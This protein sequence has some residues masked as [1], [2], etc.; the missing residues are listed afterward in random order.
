MPQPLLATKLFIPSPARS[1]VVRARLLDRLD[2]SLDPAARL[3]LVSAPP[4]FGKTTLLG[5]WAGSFREAKSQEPCRIAWLSL[6]EGDNDPVLFWAYLIAAL[7]TQAEGIGAQALTWLHAPQSPDLKAAVAVLVNDLAQIPGCF[8]LILDDYHVIRLSSIHDSLSFLIERM[9]PQF[10]VVVMTRADPPLP[11]ALLRGRGQLL[12]IRLPELR[13]SD[14]EAY[15]YLSQSAANALSQSDAARL[16]AKAEGWAA[17][18]QMAG[19]SLRG[20]ANVE[21]F[22]TSFSGNSRYILDYLIEEVLNRQTPAVQDFLLATSILDRLSGPLCDSLLAAPETEV[23]E[24][25]A[26]L[27]SGEMLRQLEDSNL[28]IS[29]LDDQRYWYRY[30]RLFADLLTKRL[31]QI[32]PARVGVLHSRASRW[33]EENGFADRAV[34]HAFKAQDYSRAARLVEAL[35]DDLWKQGE[36]TRLLKWL[37]ELTDEQIRAQLPLA[38]F[39]AGLLVL[40]GNLREAELCLDQADEDLPVA[41]LDGALLDRLIGRA[42][43]VRALIAESRADGAGILHYAHL[44]LE[45]LSPSLDAVWRIMALVALGHQELTQGH[46][47]ACKQHLFLA[48]EIGRSAGCF[49]LLLDTMTKLVLALWLAGRL[50]E[51]ADVC[52]EGLQLIDQNGLDRIPATS[53]LYLAWGFILFESRRSEEAKHFIL[54][55]LDL[56]RV[57]DNVISLAWAY[58][59]L[60]IVLTTQGDVAAAEAANREAYQLTQKY[61]LPSWLTCSI[62]GQKAFQLIDSG[63]L[64][65]AEQF[66]QSRD[67]RLDGLMAHPHQVEYE[68]LAYLLEAR[69]ELAAAADLLERLIDTARADRQES[70]VITYQTRLCLVWQSLGDKARALEVLDAALSLAE[71]EGTLEIFVGKGEPMARLLYDA[72][73]QGT[74]ADFARRLLAMFPMAATPLPTAP[75]AQQ[76]EHALIEPLSDREIET[77][78]LVAAGLS[79][80]EIAQRLHISVRTVKF[81]MTNIYGK[82]G[83]DSRTQALARAR[84]LGLILDA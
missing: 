50:K 52:Q 71:P 23:G 45:K 48:V 79:N 25:G 74:H 37:Q 54:R 62:A 60:A 32:A 40:K 57:G 18:L 53:M 20:Q 77:I 24:I 72:A 26:A 47:P 39:K 68:A 15:S 34:E 27:S 29:A 35:A 10:H 28:F 12:E 13:F 46:F 41:P 5:A 30:H 66:L 11:L 33:Y 59:E 21:A 43:T 19:A 58:H 16:N 7:Q 84:L 67:I 81:H 61:E 31:S 4:G 49:F 83:V 22:I 8:V 69:G 3:T 44:A 82:L 78:R 38:I 64:A 70:W 6:D 76:R 73:K 42:A 75:A 2:D 14:D 63:R 55:G 56:S 65:E 80:K 17:G 51:A 1:L 36:H 9:P